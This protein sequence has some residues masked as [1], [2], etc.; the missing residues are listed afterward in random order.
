MFH[1]WRDLAVLKSGQN[2]CTEAF[3]FLK[4]QIK[5][6]LDYGEMQ[7]EFLNNIE[8]AFEKNE[9]KVAEIERDRQGD[10]H[11]DNGLE[12]PLDF[13]PVETVNA[14]K[15]F[16]NVKDLVSENELEQMI[17]GLNVDQKRIFD[18]ICKTLLDESKKL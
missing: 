18:K 10:D 16:R 8:K 9:E 15:D 13:L 1:P 3:N 17:E 11:K 7:T 2:T 4:D 12:N 14:M 6:G 5:D